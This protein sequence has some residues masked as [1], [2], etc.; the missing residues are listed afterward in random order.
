MTI[1]TTIRTDENP[2]RNT[3]PITHQFENYKREKPPETRVDD[4]V[5]VN[6]KVKQ[7]PRENQ[8]R[9]IK[10]ISRMEL[11]T[12]LGRSLNTAADIDRWASLA[13]EI[14]SNTLNLNGVFLL[15]N[16]EEGQTILQYAYGLFEDRLDIQQQMSRF[17]KQTTDKDLFPNRAP[18]ELGTSYIVPLQS[19]NQ[20]KGFL[21]LGN[22]VNGGLFLPEDLS[23]IHCY[24][25]QILTSLENMK[26]QEK[27][28]KW[29][30][31]LCRVYEELKKV[32]GCLEQSETST[33][34]LISHSVQ[35]L[36][37]ALELHDRYMVGHSERVAHHAKMLAN[38][39]ISDENERKRI[40]QAAK[41]H[42]LGKIAIPDHILSKKGKLEADEIAE[43]HL[44]PLRSVDLVN[45]LPFLNGELPAIKHH[46]EWWNGKGYP[47][48]LKKENI[49]L[50]ARLLAVCDAYDAMTST[51]PYREAIGTKEALREL[52]EGASAQ[53]DPEM[54]SQFM[55]SVQKS[56]MA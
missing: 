23:F 52:E 11:L 20:T 25:Q 15:M 38:D 53:W 10:E 45:S 5:A 44:H 36:V 35:G 49:P 26:V 6:I 3:P 19:S 50:G 33:D 46:H 51:R 8:S 18:K 32:H 12:P 34:Q 13:A 30:N 22:K 31:E 48:G 39:V 41:L 43:I 28:G 7:I 9:D 1:K 40:V 2:R 42:D 37:N 54:V 29:A 47:E 21:F 4:D 17:T 56:K 27:V 16:N 14:C 24:A 55:K